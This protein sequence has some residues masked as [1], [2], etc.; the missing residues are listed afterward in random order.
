MPHRQFSAYQDWSTWSYH[1][2]ERLNKVTTRSFPFSSFR[3][4]RE[5]HVLDS[6]NHS[7]HHFDSRST[8]R[9][10]H[11]HGYSRLLLS[12]FLDFGIQIDSI[13][14]P[15]KNRVLKTCLIVGLL[16][17]MIILITASLSSNTNN[18]A[19]WFADWTFDGTKSMSFTTSILL[20]DF[21]RFVNIDHRSPW[22]IWNTRNISKNRNN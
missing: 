7:P 15:I 3:I 9:K 17:L 19:S 12:T 6:S 21:W 13:E 1:L 20:W 11:C 5:Q 22:I 8:A 4:D 16:P 10:S 2:L 18:K 14:Q